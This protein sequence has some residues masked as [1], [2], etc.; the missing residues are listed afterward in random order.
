[1]F[2]T[3]DGVYFFI[4]VYIHLCFIL[5]TALALP[6]KPTPLNTDA[7]HTLLTPAASK[8]YEIGLA[9]GLDEDTLNNEARSG[10]STDWLRL[11]E[12]C[13]LYCESK[14]SWEE[15]VHLLWGVEELEIADRICRKERLPSECTV[16]C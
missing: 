11:R 4:L 6:P 9:M 3:S 14:H 2:R 15:V 16:P 8:W 12:I 10:N 5:E 13:G 7:L 1:M